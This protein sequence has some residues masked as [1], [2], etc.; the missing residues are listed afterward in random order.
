MIS[1]VAEIFDLFA[2]YG[3][4]LYGEDVSLERHML[5]TATLAQSQG[6]PN[7]VVAAALL[8]DIGHFLHPDGEAAAGSGRDLEHEALG[9]LWLSRGF[10]EAVTAPIALHVR[11]KQYLCA[12]EPAYVDRLSE[13]S[14]VSLAAQGGAMSQDEAAGFEREPGF[15]AALL[16]R[17][18]DD[19]GKDVSVRT[20]TVEDFRGLLTSCLRPAA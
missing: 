7:S 10:D 20:A 17:R 6:A 2:R 8:H 13:A 16:L 19:G 14:R 1:I 3:S 9:A 4:R 18:C 15:E 12:V 5:Q 11:A